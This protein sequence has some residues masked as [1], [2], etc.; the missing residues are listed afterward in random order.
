MGIPGLLKEIGKG[1]RVALSKLALDHFEKHKRPLRIAIDA[2][3]WNFQQQ[4]GQG[5]KNPALRTLFYRLVRLLALPIHPV[6]VYDGKNKPLTKRG[7]TVSRYGTCIPNEMSKNLVARFQFPHHTAPGEAEAE[8]AFLQK[9]GIVDAVMS[10]DVDA[11]MFGSTLT[12]R[13][14]SKEGSKGNKAP[15]HVSNYDGGRIKEFTGLTSDG[16]VLVALLSGG[17]YHEG[18]SGFGPAVSC[19][20]ARAGFGEELTELIQ[21]DDETG[22]S[23]WRERLQYELETNESGYFQKRH[24]T[25]KIPDNFP[26]RTVLGYY[27]DP[28]V[29]K[30]D[31]LKTLETRWIQW[32]D[33]EIDIKALREY[34]AMTFDWMYKGGAMKFIRCMAQPL[35]Q[36]RLKTNRVDASIYTI[37]NIH[38]RRKHH[39]NDGASELRFSG[40]PLREVGIDLDAEEEN[41]EFAEIGNEQDDE[42]IEAGV[43]SARAESVDTDACP[44]SQT[45]TRKH[46]PWNPNADEKWWTPELLLRH[47]MPKLLSEWDA[48]QKAI[49]SDPLRFATR[50][51]PPSKTAAKA[52]KK[53]DR[54]VQDGALEQFLPV[55]KSTNTTKRA[56]RSTAR[57][58]TA[59]AKKPLERTRSNPL[60]AL[61]TQRPTVESYFKLSK[62]RGLKNDTAQKAIVTIELSDSDA[63]DIRLKTIEVVSKPILSR[64]SSVP[65]APL[66]M[67]DTDSDDELVDALAFITQRRRQ[68]GIP[69]LE[70]VIEESPR[71]VRPVQSP[72]AA[73]LA[74]DRNELFDPAPVSP[75]IAKRLK[76]SKVV[77]RDSLPGTWKELDLTPSRASNVQI[78]DLTED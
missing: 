60:E 44:S 28:A 25:L 38:D 48:D 54:A 29:T 55:T 77:S 26:D 65:V 68:R 53:I 15:T 76:S 57:P 70:K 20:I 17:D 7:K 32:W 72:K 50:K 47:G 2:A 14:W 9:H 33:K 36:H 74:Y 58:E 4:A 45:Q 42:E 49:Y 3:I 43:E 22:L 13:D 78:I 75:K 12:L 23:E 40:N 21:R 35:F 1:D 18:V 6:F 5:G 52:P 10:Q 56:V 31:D 16:M 73:K 61:P 39:I 63:E 59:R 69:G 30:K 27:L 71:A 19:S 11:I 37:Q 8:C 51:C 34:V 46:P 41:P 64:S 62:S 67:N 24:K 66:Q